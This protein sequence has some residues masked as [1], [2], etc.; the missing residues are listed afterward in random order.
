MLSVLYDRR[1]FSCTMNVFRL[2]LPHFIRFLDSGNFASK[3]IFFFYLY[4]E[5]SC[6]VA[7]IIIIVVVQILPNNIF[8]QCRHKNHIVTKNDTVYNKFIY[9]NEYKTPLTEKHQAKWI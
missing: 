5:H 8:Q 3:K 6:I 7:T 1:C 4:T 9:K 2:F